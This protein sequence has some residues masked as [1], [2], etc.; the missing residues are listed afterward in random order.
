[1]VRK[2]VK[3]VRKGEG[4]EVRRMYGKGKFWVW[5]RTEMHSESG[6]NDDDDDDDDEP[7]RERWDYS[8]RDSSSTVGEVL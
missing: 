1:M 5:S 3:S 4:Y 8:D 7:V 2:L 6:D